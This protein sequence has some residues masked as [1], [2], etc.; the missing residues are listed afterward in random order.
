MREQSNCPICNA[1]VTATARYCTHCGS[2]ITSVETVVDATTG[3]RPTVETGWQVVLDLLQDTTR[4]RFEIERELGQGGMAAVYLAHEKALDR[5]VALKVMSPA[6]L[7]QEGMVDRFRLEAIT[8]ASLKHPNIVTV[9]GVEHHGQLHFFVLEFVE[10]RSLEQ[11][12]KTHG[13]LPIPVIKAWA[14][15]VG[16][17]LEYAHRRGVVHRDIKPANILIDAE[18]NAV[19]TDF[20]IAK[21]ET[22][23]GQTATGTVIGTPAYMSPEQCLGHEIT[24]A[25]DQYSL[26]VVVYEMLTGKP[27]FDGPTFTV[28]QAHAHEAPPPI[29]QRRSDCP[30]PVVD[31]VHRTLAKDPGDRWPAISDCVAALGAA[32]PAPGQAVHTQMALV[33]R[34]EVPTVVL[35]DPPT[36]DTALP[37]R[38]PKPTAGR[39]RQSRV[40]PRLGMGGAVVALGIALWLGGPWVL[41][42]FTGATS[43]TGSGTAASVEITPS[44]VNLA[45]GDSANL[46]ATVT[47]SESQ[48]LDGLSVAWRSSDTT[49]ATVNEGLV[50]GR[51]EGLVTI[52]ASVAGVT[53][54]TAVNVTSPVA[55]AAVSLAPNPVRLEPGGTVQM[56]LTVQQSDG[57]L[58]A[59]RMAGWQSD[60][61]QIASID[62]SGIVRAIGVGTTRISAVVDG[63]IGDA[64]VDVRSVSRGEQPPLASVDISPDFVELDVGE[65]AELAAD[66]L[67]TRGTVRQA[68]RIVWTS[69]A[70]NVS[71]ENGRVTAIRPGTAVITASAG[72][73]S[74]QVRVTVRDAAVDSV[75]LDPATAS[76]TVG[77]SIRLSPLVV[78]A[79]GETVSDPDI[80]WRSTN[81]AVANVAADGTVSG[82]NPG[83][84]IVTATSGTVMAQATIN[85][86]AAEVL[87]F[88]AASE[89][90]DQFVSQFVAELNT[91]MAQRDLEGVKQAYRAPMSAEDEDDWQDLLGNRDFDEFQASASGTFVP[92]RV[93][94]LW[95]TD[96]NVTIR[97]RHS[98]GSDSWEQSYRMEFSATPDGPAVRSLGLRARR[99]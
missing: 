67:D 41:A 78:D 94:D 76:V 40:V 57:G 96:F 10:G 28:M 13:A 74:G 5:K 26:G 53:Q 3:E 33:A 81:S 82:V 46:R 62:D 77:N 12:I 75:S 54:S 83:T 2:D 51:T 55:V 7:L 25:S 35:S 36:P 90:S 18:G 61:P 14:A 66:L 63:V 92:E 20:G 21:V 72:G 45:V 64:S 11:V 9:H 86:V 8:I 89:W 44:P 1:A 32:I 47:D 95:Q 65:T 16:G 34:G 99:S 19:V 38:S 4:G 52:T 37:I 43:D 71:V 23:P 69:D 48:I 58:L 84:A 31:A 30:Q 56:Q 91:A 17:A 27:P 68:G 79:L 70:D 22:K 24:G 98:R 85:V 29:P 97:F 15:Q 87:D 59:E 60:N 49:V 6:V 93:G 50:I 42:R 73:V 80:A 39:A 88:G